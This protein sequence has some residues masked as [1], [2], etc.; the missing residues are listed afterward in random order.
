MRIGIFGTVLVLA[1]AVFLISLYNHVA[2][3]SNGEN[4]VEDKIGV[5]V[6]LPPQAE[7]VEEV[8]G[9][10]VR[11]TVMIPSGANPHTYE[12]KPSQLKGL[13]AARMYAKVGTNIEFELEWLDEV[14]SMNDEILVVD[15]SR[16]INFIG[17]EPHIWLSPGNAGIMT[18]NIYEG[19]AKLDPANKKYYSNNKEKYLQKLYELDK[20]IIK[21][22]SRKKNRK[23]LIYHAEWAY[24]ARDYKLEEIAAEKEGKEPSARRIAGLIRLAKE[25]NIV[26]VFAS[27]E[28]NTGSAEIIAKEI[29]GRVVFVNPLKKN[30][31]ENMQSIAEAFAE[32]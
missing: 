16:G 15:C 22:L 1:S 12:P 7:F 28:F 32:N 3:I 21:S 25:N 23:I 2:S 19:L 30:Y 8:G 10:K 26:R 5:V 13:R 17:N 14:L 6:T 18:E 29:G 11:V 27:P 31:L 20:E 24:F 4:G 9:N